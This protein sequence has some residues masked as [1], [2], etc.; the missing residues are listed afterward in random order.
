MIKVEFTC[1]NAQELKTLLD[2]LTTGNEAAA[3][4]YEAAPEAQEG[5]NTTPRRKTKQKATQPTVEE[6]AAVAPAENEPAREP[7]EPDQAPTVTLQD[8]QTLGR[9]LA[10]AGKGPEIQRILKARGVT[11]LSRIPEDKRAEV[12]AEMQEVNQDGKQ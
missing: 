3:S 5:S 8:L 1:A 4:A 9:K 6:I 11:L 2:L 7:E 12:Y 10:A